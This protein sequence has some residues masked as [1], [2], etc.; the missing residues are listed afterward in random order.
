MSLLVLVQVCLP[1][2][3]HEFSRQAKAAHLFKTSATFPYDNIL[4]SEFSKAF[5]GIERLDMFFPFDP[6]LLKQS[7]R[8]FFI[9]ILLETLPFCK[10]CYNA[11]DMF[12]R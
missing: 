10:F 8:F 11:H 3:V 6:Y 4:E 2:I 1:T 5:G 7:E 12:I 9:S